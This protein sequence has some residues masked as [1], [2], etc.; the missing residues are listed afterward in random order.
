MK[1][2]DEKGFTMIELLAV[3][4]LL[5]I[6]TGIAVPAVYRYL[7]K[8]RTVSTEVMTKSAYEAAA[9]YL[10][11]ENILLS[12]GGRTEVSIKDLVEYQ[13]LEPIIDPIS[14]ED[15]C[16]DS[17]NSKVEI[18]RTDTGVTGIPVYKYIVSIDC[19]SFEHPATGTF[20]EE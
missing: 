2:L 4:A 3:V 20:P 19:P 7:T 6:L 5:A 10:M 9:D 1:K 16:A 15:N 13:Y 17:E 12:P 8:S 11:H 18:T 14:K